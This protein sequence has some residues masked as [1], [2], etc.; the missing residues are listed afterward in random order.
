[1][2][3]LKA[4]PKREQNKDMT[5]IYVRAM[6]GDKWRAVD[7]AELTRESLEMWLNTLEKHQLVKMIMV[8]LGYG[9]DA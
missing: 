9:K 2:M 6:D 5:G 4:D 1:M 8:G 3:E 7:I